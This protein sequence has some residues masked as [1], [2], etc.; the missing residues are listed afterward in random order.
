MQIVIIFKSVT[1]AQRAERILAKK[2]VTSN[3]IKAPFGKNSGS[4]AYGVKI[5]DKYIAA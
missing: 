1:Y 2:G 3:I 4:C 5:N